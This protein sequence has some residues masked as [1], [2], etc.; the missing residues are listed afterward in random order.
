[1]IQ[2]IFLVKGDNLQD[3]DAL[4][5]FNYPR[6]I[7]I[8]D[9]SIIEKLFHVHDF[10]EL[11]K[12]H[13]E[14]KESII[15]EQL[16]YLD[17]PIPQIIKNLNIS[18]ICINGNIIIG[19]IFDNSDNSHDYEHFFKELIYE[20]ILNEKRCSFE[21]E[22]EIENFLITLFIDIRGYNEEIMQKSSSSETLRD[23][24]FTKIFLF[25]LDE[26]GKSSLVRRIKTGDYSDNFFT[27]TK[28]FSIEYIEDEEM[29]LLAFWDMPGQY[30]FRRKWLTGSQDSNILIY[31]ID[32]SDQIRFAESKK[33]LDFI[34][35]HYELIEVPLLVIGNK[36]DLINHL[37]MGNTK[38]SVDHLVRLRKEIFEYFGLKEIENRKW[39]FLF[40]SVKT[41]YNVNRIN[42][43]ITFLISS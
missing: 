33:E 5:I 40:T 2:N 11:K 21:E 35:N 24:T 39:E 14:K 30:L 19:L 7:I 25:G 8:K 20:L 17:D 26:V 18:T 1:M 10:K 12:K 37:N 31:M 13:K 6:D 3:I 29:G 38:D 36:I 9:K 34:I 42:Q 22:I 4:S 23:S 28:K 16:F 32:V 27:P 41:N 15:D 43:F